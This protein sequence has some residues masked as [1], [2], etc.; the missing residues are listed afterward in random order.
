M[1]EYKHFTIRDLKKETLDMVPATIEAMVA[2]VENGGANIE[3]F[4]YDNGPILRFRIE[5]KDSQKQRYLLS[6]LNSSKAFK[7]K[8]TVKG[9]YCPH[10]NTIK[11]HAVSVD[12]YDYSQ[13]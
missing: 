7:V 13:L 12:D 2:S 6:L 3:G 9:V 4:L 1:S 10:L 5:E 11:L 8:A